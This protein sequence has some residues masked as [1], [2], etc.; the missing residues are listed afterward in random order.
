MV[1]IVEI[2]LELEAT[3]FINNGSKVTRGRVVRMVPGGALGVKVDDGIK[4]TPEPEGPFASI[5]DA[6]AAI[7][8]YWKKCN[9]ALEFHSWNPKGRW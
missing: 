3:G 4:G 6:R 9:V 2:V 8:D 7:I 5:D 1:E